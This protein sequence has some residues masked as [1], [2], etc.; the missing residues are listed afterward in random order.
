MHSNEC[1]GVRPFFPMLEQLALS[2]VPDNQMK[3]KGLLRSHGQALVGH[4]EVQDL[5][6]FENS[7]EGPCLPFIKL[8]VLCLIEVKPP[9]GNNAL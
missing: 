5:V 7:L 1:V 8:H 9:N 2:V 4:N 6:W 3:M